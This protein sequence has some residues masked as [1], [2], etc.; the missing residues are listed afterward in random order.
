MTFEFII[1]REKGEPCKSNN[2]TFRR[3]W[4]QVVQIKMVYEESEY[5]L[6]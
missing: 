1:Y 3:E 5:D 6:L 4:F 2:I